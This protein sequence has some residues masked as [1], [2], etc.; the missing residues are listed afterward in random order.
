MILPPHLFD[1]AHTIQDSIF[2]SP[3]AISQHAAL[4][5]LKHPEIISYFHSYVRE[6]R[7]YAYNALKPLEEKKIISMI[8]PPAAFYLFIKTPDNDTTD[9]CFDIAQKAGVSVVPGKAFGLDHASFLRI[10]F[11]REKH[12][13]EE[14]VKRFVHYWEDF[15]V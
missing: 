9:R 7:D 6:N 8:K 2:I 11:A 12:V 15:Y 13:L 5:A 3:C 10:C 14:G 1:M 4:E